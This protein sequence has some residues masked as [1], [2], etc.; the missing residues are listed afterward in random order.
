M[1]VSIIIPT[2]NRADLL[3]TC[4]DSVQDNTDL[5][6]SEVIVISNGCKDNTV[7][8]VKSYGDKFKV[9]HWP[10]PLG[11]SRAVNAGIAVAKGDYFILLNNDTKI[12]SNQINWVDLLLEPFKLYRNVGITGPQFFPSQYA[13]TPC[14]FFFCVAISRS[15]IDTIGYFNTDFGVGGNE[16]LDYCIRAYRAGFTIHKTLVH[17]GCRYEFPAF[18]IGGATRSVLPNEKEIREANNVLF[19]KL[20]GKDAIKF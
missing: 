1:K 16:D 20:Y 3:K 4:L 11:F 8:L 14:L 15:V 17:S 9:Y 18:H 5:T 13:N 19:Y 2:F 7:D 10:E 6:D 12:F